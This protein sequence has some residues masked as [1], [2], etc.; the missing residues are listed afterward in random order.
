[1]GRLLYS[2][3]Q[4]GVGWERA[5][6]SLAVSPVFLRLRR[7]KMAGARTGLV[8]AAE[9]RSASIF[10]TGGTKNA[11]ATGQS[12]PNQTKPGLLITSHRH[13][14]RFYRCTSPFRGTET[15]ASAEKCRHRPGRLSDGG[16]GH[17]GLEP[18]RNPGGG[19]WVA[20]GPNWTRFHTQALA[21]GARQLAVRTQ[22]L[23][24][25]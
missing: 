13:G 11:T 16:G 6:I 9:P 24:P 20:G 12:R 7:N 15:L 19:F 18:P 17:V 2:V 14:S 23:D 22:T 21:A 4:P 1:M 8:L 25:P 3:K 10:E 5:D